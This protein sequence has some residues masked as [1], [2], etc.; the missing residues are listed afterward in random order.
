MG[1]VRHSLV[2]AWGPQNALKAAFLAHM[3]MCGLLVLFGI[4]CRFRLAYLVG[5]MIIVICLFLEHFIA[6]RRSLKWINVAFFR[7][8]ALVGVV[9]LVM[10]AVEVIFQ[11]GFRLR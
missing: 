7:L 2:V 11:G 10:V 4:L 3:I 6:Q 1:L 8:N 5:W 9:F